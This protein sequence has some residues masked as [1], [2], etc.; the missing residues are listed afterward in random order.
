[1]F[2]TSKVKL[3]PSFPG[4]TGVTDVKDPLLASSGV[5][6]TC[7][8]M[9]SGAPMWAKFTT[10]CR[11]ANVVAKTK[12]APVAKATRCMTQFSPRNR[13]PS[14]QEGSATILYDGGTVTRAI[15]EFTYPYPQR[16]EGN[17]V[18]RIWRSRYET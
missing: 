15:V 6:A 5:F 3:E 11:T 8:T 1:M 4:G 14:P 7:V 16:Y 9:A 2:T 17:V 13:E 18:K 12:T 10:V